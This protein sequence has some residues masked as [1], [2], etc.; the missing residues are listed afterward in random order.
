MRHRHGQQRRQTKT[1]LW[2]VQKK[3][4]EESSEDATSAEQERCLKPYTSCS[5]QSQAKAMEKYQKTREGQHNV[6]GRPLQPGPQ[7]GHPKVEN[8]GETI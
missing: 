6:R 8:L 3:I 2:T 5:G 1:M 4:S 7:T